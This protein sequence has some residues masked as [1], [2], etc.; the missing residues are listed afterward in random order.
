MQ[1]TILQSGLF[2]TKETDEGIEIVGYTGTESR[3]ELPE[4]IDGK[5]VVALGF[6]GKGNLDGVTVVLSSGISRIA[7][8][9]YA[10]LHANYSGFDPYAWIAGV[11]AGQDHPHFSSLGNW[12]FAKDHQTVVAY[13]DLGA[14]A[15]AIPKNVRSILPYAFHSCALLSSVTIPEYVESVGDMAFNKNTTACI[16]SADTRLGVNI[17]GKIELPGVKGGFVLSKDGKRLIKAP[18]AN[19]DVVLPE[20]VETIDDYAFQ[21]CYTASVT[22]NEGLRK[23]GHHAF[24]GTN[25]QSLEIP[26]TV[27]EMYP[28]SFARS[29]Y[30][31]ISIRMQPGNPHYRTVG[32]ILYHV[33]ADGSHTLFCVQNT[34]LVRAEIPGSVK[35]LEGTP[36]TACRKLT[37]I[38]LSEG[39]ERLEESCLMVLVRNTGKPVTVAVPSTVKELVLPEEG[40]DHR[41]RYRFHED[42]PVYFTDGDLCYQTGADGSHTLLFCQNRMLGEALIHEDTTAIAP[43]AFMLDKDGKPL[44]SRLKTLTLPAGVK[45]IAAT[46]FEGCDKLQSMAVAADSDTFTA[47]DGVLFSKDM[48]RLAV[49]PQ[50]KKDKEYTLPE[51]VEAFGAAFAANKHLK[52]LHLNAGVSSIGDMA[53]PESCGIEHL[54]MAGSIGR[55]SP[56]AFG[57]KS[58]EARTR[59]TPITIHVHDAGQLNRYLQETMQS[60]KGNIVVECVNE[61]PETK[62][63]KKL[64]AFEQVEDGLRLTKYLGDRKTETELVIPAAIGDVPVV[65]LGDRM[66]A[67]GTPL[68]GIIIPEGVKRL[69]ESALFTGPQC[70]KMVIPASVTEISP[71][72]FA[73]SGHYFKDAYLRG[74]TTITVVEDSYADRFLSQYKVD[75][76]TRPVVLLAGQDDHLQFE[77]KGKDCTATLRAGAERID[78]LTVPAAHRGKP[79]TRLVLCNAKPED[80]FDRE[81]PAENILSLTIPETVKTIVG[82]H[83]YHPT[84]KTPDGLPALIIAEDNPHFWTDGR[85]LYTKNR[86]TL[87]FMVDDSPEEYTV[88]AGTTAIG[89]YAFKHIRNLTK[90]TLPASIRTLGD[91]CFYG[92]GSIEEIS[93]LE[94]VTKLG[95]QA[96]MGSGYEQ[97]T[98]CIIIGKELVSYRGKDAVFHVPEGVETIGVRAFMTFGGNCTLKELVLPSTLRRI[99]ACAFI[100]QTVLEMIH[101]PEGLECIEEKAFEECRGLRSIHLPASLKELS[102]RAFFFWAYRDDPIH[103]AEVTVAEGNPRYCAVDGILYNKDCT[104]M[105]LLPPALEAEELRIPETVRTV[106]GEHRCNGIKRLVFTGDI[107]KWEIGF[108]G[109]RNLKEVVFMGSCA[110]IPDGAFSGCKKLSK[111]TFPKDLKK[112]GGRAFLQTMLAK[113]ELPD[114]LEHIGE[115]AFARCGIK[116]ITLPASVRTLGWGAFS[117]ADEIGVYDTIEPDAKPANDDVDT[118]NG[119]PNG[120]VGYIGMGEA[121]AMWQCAANHKWRD[122]TIAVRSAE[123][124]D[125]KY[126]VWMG[127]DPSQRAYYCLL[128]SG[129]GR[130]AT[131]AFAH[132]DEFFSRIRGAEHKL[133]VAQ[134]R[135]EYPVELSDETKKKYEAYVKKNAPKGE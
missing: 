43:H 15:V 72:V 31:T 41:I 128:S 121:K 118:V 58:S 75:G 135:L 63:W 28:D 55:I 54:Y 29:C 98:P 124:G 93:G 52:T 26:A 116:T 12:L 87:L 66:F 70:K 16:R 30:G 51:T 37:D 74:D 9:A 69:G 134:L 46:A 1:D 24:F 49:Y 92:C 62:R 104:E 5:P 38:I 77:I 11:E 33:E 17:A 99:E 76:C 132:L 80:A 122:Y 78:R 102:P 88:Q 44:F 117:G 27:E 19:D 109:S 45:D 81:V 131:F 59:K 105:L 39:L 84:E 126:K 67:E 108:A 100:N 25:V 89:D 64:F 22:L 53:F 4:T 103:L 20:G 21:K 8:D 129:W 133:R 23:I 79:V 40:H 101:L 14:M 127:A 107:E 36:F 47:V 68:T 123:T 32:G 85:A 65:E 34:A 61:S 6:C 96:L 50:D 91:Y 97:K 110:Q 94:A 73:G 71:W 10:M 106:V 90:V 130:N 56:F 35:A 18:A 7:P 113:P 125:I 48:R 83:K 114:T 95:N 120:M 60:A 42:N 82:I 3:V 119:G 13:F 86:K 112:I 111:V 2:L 57:R 115:E